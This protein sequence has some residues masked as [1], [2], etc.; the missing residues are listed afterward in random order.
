MVL[1][2]KSALL[3]SVSSPFPINISIPVV[4]VVAVELA[5]ALRSA[6]EPVDG[7]P[8]AVPSASFV[9]PSPNLSITVPPLF[10]K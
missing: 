5:F 1:F 8:F 2:T 6:L 7:L 4:S 3:L 9:L 10:F